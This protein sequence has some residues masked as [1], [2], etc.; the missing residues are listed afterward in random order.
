MN[1]PAVPLA[2][3]ARMMR[4]ARDAI[5]DVISSLTAT[6]ANETS[7]PFAEIENL[8]PKHFPLASVRIV[9]SGPAGWT[10]W[11]DQHAVSPELTALRSS[12]GAPY[13]YSLR[14][15]AKAAF[16]PI[17]DD[18]IGLIVTQ[19]PS[20]PLP[21]HELFVCARLL[22]MT[23]SRCL[24]RPRVPS[25]HEIIIAF[26]HVAN[27]ILKSEDLAEIFFN[28]TQVANSELSADICGIMLLDG[29]YLVMQRCVGNESAATATLRMK[30]GQGIAGRVLQTGEPC[31]V[32]DYLSS[33]HI[34]HDFFDLARAERV[35]SALAVPLF[36][37]RE[38]IGALEVWR[39]RPST[40][41][42]DNVAELAAL[43]DLA[44]LAIAN[45]KLISSQKSAMHE[46]E[47]AHAAMSERIDI[48]ENA[49]DFQTNLV[50]CVIYDQGL[51]QIVQMAAEAIEA[52]VFICDQK[53]EIRAQSGSHPL[54]AADLA[55]LRL[56]LAAVPRDDM[57]ARAITFGGRRQTVYAQ[58]LS[59]VSGQRGWALILKPGG[60]RDA[61][62]L[63]LA[64]VSI[65]VALFDVKAQAASSVLSEKIS[66]LLWDLIDAPR[67]VR[68]LAIEKLRELGKELAAPTSVILCG[69]ENR[70]K[71]SYNRSAELDFDLRRS[72][73][74]DLI[75]YEQTGRKSTH[76][77]A[78]RD[79]EIAVVLSSADPA[80]LDRFLR[81]LGDQIRK[82]FPDIRWA[83]GVSTS[84]SDPLT[85]PDALTEARL[86]K[87]VAELT[88]AVRPV[89]FED[90]GL[91]GLIMG[92]QGGVGFPGFAHNVLKDIADE[93]HPQAA[94]L[95]ETLRAYL[96]SNCSQRDAAEMLT[97]HPKTIAYRLEKIETTS[98]LS[99]RNHEHRIMLELALKV[100]DLG[101]ATLKS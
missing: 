24:E 48:I 46:L 44:S 41:T 39:R 50:K 54:N 91:L 62:L 64:S 38:I 67:R 73:V 71:D 4:T 28:I 86:A 92:L 43:A 17:R 57:A 78:F 72:L 11:D 61:T 42:Q 37:N 30:A 81:R 33:R 83:I 15:S 70:A 32:E 77:A 88:S 31:A 21:E 23:V 55:K 65:T 53:L 27:T 75:A 93:S 9:V 20:S 99:L 66:A 8:L 3:P 7:Y 35:R 49:A 98:G 74:S 1:D 69:I 47:A 26:S 85:L 80:A 22:E 68:V 12:G 101:I 18:A 51:D 90:M 95:R 16:F 89:K 45:A 56:E 19:A 94:T 84:R 2:S 40:F 96:A 25:R 10:Y 52:S 60:S 34:S 59:A 97:V 87:K 14:L 29:D 82:I 13:A 79:N 6:T 76:L 58:R 100:H 5:K 63:A 36:S